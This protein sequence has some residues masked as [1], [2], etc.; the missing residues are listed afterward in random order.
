MGRFGNMCGKSNNNSAVKPGNRLLEEA[1]ECA[2]FI[3]GSRDIGA[4]FPHYIR[5]NLTLWAEVG[6][7][8]CLRGEGE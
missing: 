4:N 3:P 6:E 7:L 8:C 2:G 1:F 5:M